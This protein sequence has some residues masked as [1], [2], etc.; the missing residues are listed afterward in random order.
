MCPLQKEAEINKRLDAVAV[1]TEP[2]HADFI[3]DL[4]FQLK[5]ISDLRSIM[6]R[7]R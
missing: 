4:Q 6:L 2:D 3:T 5:S 7:I 1:F